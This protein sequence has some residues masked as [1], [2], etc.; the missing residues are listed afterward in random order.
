MKKT[1]LLLGA[2]LFLPLAAFAGPSYNYIQ[3]DYIIDGDAE[4]QNTL[5]SDHY[6]GW[7]AQ[8]SG[9]LLPHLIVQAQHAQLDIS[10]GVGD[11]DI[12]SIAVG[13][14]LS[15]ATGNGGSIDAYGTI[16]YE[17]LNDTVDASGYGVNI[18][19]RLLPVKFIEV[20]PFVSYVDYG[21]LENIGGARADLDGIR[22]GVEFIGNIT[23][24]LGITASYRQT[25]LNL[26]SPGL[27]DNFDVELNDEFR[28][29]IRLYL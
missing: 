29:G 5:S 23:Q 26:D 11:Q 18:G 19:L 14:Y 22:Y 3:G 28:V 4:T 6:D 16:S 8:F 25:E 15:S 9:E 10:N 17:L 21:Q 20:N 27:V 1:S 12:S 7:N 2:G 24:C 13:G